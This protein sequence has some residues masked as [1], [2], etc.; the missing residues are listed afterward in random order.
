M[1]FVISNGGCFERIIF[2]MQSIGLSTGILC[3]TAG[4]KI[5]LF[6]CCYL[7]SWAWLFGVFGF[8]LGGRGLFWDLSLQIPLSLVGL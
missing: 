8:L 5:P 4:R 7:V 3:A 2:H 6:L 1:V